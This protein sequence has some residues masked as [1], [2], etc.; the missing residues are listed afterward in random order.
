LAAFHE[1]HPAVQVRAT[2]SDSGSVMQDVEKGHAIIGLVGQEAEK[3][4]L[5]FRPIGSDSLV[6][7]VGS[8][9]R[10]ASRKRVSI[11]ELTCEPMIIRE[12]RS[13]S[14]RALEGSLMRSGIGLARLKITLELGS[15]AAIKDA[16]RLGL[17]VAFLSKLAVQKELDAHDLQAVAVSG[18]SIVRHFYLVFQRGRPLSAAASAFLR[19]AE[20]C[21]IR[22]IDR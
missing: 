4:N 22:S 19:C 9:H 18:L 11:N 1:A 3:S 8:G 14:R 17:G 13:G 20:A 6:L 12:R 10:W 15:N 21:P 16:V 5:E 2:V 7:V